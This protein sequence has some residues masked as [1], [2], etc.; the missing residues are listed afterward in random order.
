MA[1]IE[2]KKDVLERKELIKLFVSISFSA[3]GKQRVG[4]HCSFGAGV[5]LVS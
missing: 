3:E 1:H 5:F 2:H 4:E